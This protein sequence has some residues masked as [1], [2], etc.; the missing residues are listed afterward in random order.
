MP[1]E[2]YLPRQATPM[3]LSPAAPFAA[4]FPLRRAVL[5]LAASLLAAMP[6]PASAAD[7][8]T[9]DGGVY[10]GGMHNGR[11]H[12]QGRI[13]WR[14]GAYREGSFV[15]GLSHGAG[16]AVGAS[17]WRYEGGF[18]NGLMHGRGRM[19][20][21]D[22]AEYEGEFRADEFDG[23]G[24]YSLANG[25]VYEGEFSKGRFHGQGRL[26][27]ADG[28]V[29]IG[30]FE[31][32]EPAG[33]MQVLYGEP[34]YEGELADWEPNGPGRFVDARGNVFEGVFAAGA[35][36]GKGT[37]RMKDG[38][39]YEG[40]FDN[41]RFHG[42]GVYR[43]AD[44][45]EY[46]GA[47]SRGLYDG[48]GTMTYARPRP[49]GRLRDSGT[50]RR[51]KLYDPAAEAQRQRN[52][53]T[54]LYNQPAML[55]TQ[56]QALQPQD[57]ARIDLYLLAVAGDGREE[58]FRREVEFVRA[59]FDRDFGTAGRSL[60]LVNSRSS[61]DAVPLATQTSL[62]LALR[63]LAGR[64]DVEQ[65]ILFLFVTS[66]GSESHEL[67]LKLDGIDL[68]DLPA[69]AL[70]EMLR[71]SG[72][73]W[74][75]V[76]VSACYSGGFVDALADEGTLV[77]TS[78]RH[79]RTSFG[80]ADDNDFTYFGRAYFKESLAPAL[81]FADAFAKARGLVEAW[82]REDM[83]GVQGKGGGTGAALAEEEHSRP[84]IMAPAPIREQLRRWQ[85]QAPSR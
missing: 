4:P 19:R 16:V 41:W 6:V 18:D 8:V 17:G 81:S 57:P 82:E 77:M 74:K 30:R 49:D 31:D 33:R 20:F 73:R 9:P 12:G 32:G 61:A 84:V 5:S 72:I 64:M 63:A 71:E 24:R 51:G 59:Q 45:D 76:L 52:A 13:D 85:A 78:A 15:D 70:G 66:H 1:A 46:R 56:L 67:T 44:G 27:T 36:S 40:D 34:S 3:P 26:E 22:G 75:V 2:F 10:R 14:N 21:A 28:R 42:Q 83:A 47:F 11:L 29:Y 50:W 54:V 58:V 68:P 48:E 60:A 79:D 25:E 80:C 7:A 65:D 53:E 37:V 38:A 43:S 35:L 55:Q 69:A 39:R 23:Q 62:R